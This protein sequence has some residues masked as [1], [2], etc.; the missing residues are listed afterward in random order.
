MPWPDFAKMS[1]DDI[2]AIYE[3]LRAIP[4]I[5]HAGSTGLPAN[6]L[7]GM[8]AVGSPASDGR[9]RETVLLVAVLWSTLGQAS[10]QPVAA[11]GVW[12][13]RDL[14]DWATP[15]AEL[16]GHDGS[17]TTINEWFNPARLR[18]DY[19]PSGFKGYKVTH[20]SVPGHQ[21][22]LKLNAEDKG[23]LIAFL[24]TL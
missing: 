10:G 12:N 16:F 3:Y 24:K 20:R 14:A 13:D 19:V 5:S 1:D 7:P 2:R 4:C 15:V 9:L 17:V 8:P 11:P 21:F 23:A 6:L 22:G 18:D